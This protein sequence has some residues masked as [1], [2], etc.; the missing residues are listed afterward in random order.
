MKQNIEI[1]KI[2]DLH[3]WSENPRD[4]IDTEATDEQII[5]RALEEHPYTWNLRGLNRKML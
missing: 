1:L 4:P 3:L 2:A 5:V